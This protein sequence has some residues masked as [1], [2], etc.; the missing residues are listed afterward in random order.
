MTALPASDRAVT[1]ADNHP[2]STIQSAREAFS[3][4]GVWLREHPVIQNDADA[5]L[6]AAYIE[7]TRV[8]LGDMETERKA[9]V[10]P[11]NEQLSEINGNYREARDPLESLLKT[12]RGRLT[13]YANAVEAARI[14]E[15][16]RLRL[17]AEERERLARAAEEAEREAIDDASQGV[18]SDIGAAVEQADQAFADYRS[19]DKQAAIAERNVPL[20]LRSVMGGR[21]MSMRTVEKLVIEDAAA[22]IKALGVTP[23]IQEAILKSARAFRK[24]FDE[25]PAGIT[26]TFERSL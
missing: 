15:A 6:G 20:K 23:D 5:K 16:N 24:E 12:L 13:T 18:E 14:A 4:L 22:A 19:A 1:R 26:A 3:E 8:A 25:L 21:T 2:P 7:R 17:E 10:A 11:L 9:K